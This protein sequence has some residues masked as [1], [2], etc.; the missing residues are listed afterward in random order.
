VIETIARG[1]CIKDGHILLCQTKGAPIL[2]LPG[3]HVEFGETARAALERE[4]M[5]ELGADSVAGE[6]LGM[7]EHSF[8]QKGEP[9][10]EWN[11]VFMLDIPALDPDRPVT[12]AEDYICFHWL[13]L[14]E[15]EHST[16][17]PAVLRKSIPNWLES[18]GLADSRWAG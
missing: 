15:L 18:P 14:D 1:V 8:L 16:L 2:Y 7:V 4:I 17:E 11:A 13:A 6:F 3:G 12:A 10:S 5:E 9:H